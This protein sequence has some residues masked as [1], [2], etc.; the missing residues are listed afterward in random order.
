[1]TA[2]RRAVLAFLL[3][4]LGVLLTNLRAFPVLRVGAAPRPGVSLLVP[5]R[6]EVGR[7]A[8]T[9]GT[10]AAQ[11]V[12]ELVVLDD[13]ST[14]ATAA[15]ARTL[16]ADVPHARVVSGAPPPPG[17]VGKTWA[18][19]QLAQHAGGQVL[20]F[21]DCD[22][23]V[24]PGGLAAALAEM[25]R[26]GA[27]VFS[28]FPRQVTETWGERLTTPVVDDVLLG[29]LPFAL[30]G[31]D[32]PAAAT[33][34]GS[35]LAVTRTAH[36]ELGGFAAVRGEVVEDVALARLTR[37]RG[38]R[39]GLALGGDVVATRMYPGYA[40]A[41][42]GLGRGLLPVTGGSRL[43]LA[44]ATAWLLTVHTGPLLLAARDRRWLAP[45]LLTVGQ[46]FLVERKTRH[47]SGAQALLAPFWPVAALP[48]LATALRREQTWR[49]RSTASAARSGVGVP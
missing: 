10:L 19:H 46:R 2:L 11:P 43:R 30:L 45:L 28:V 48:V 41:V 38:L 21:A 13:C 1:M 22:V 12:D 29:F 32:V 37:R 36:D 17:W 4:K 23:A 20:V 3:L 35:L 6:D 24:A 40:A 5:V 16:L 9:L 7:L 49:G 44:A 26:Q 25:D 33:A 15:L 39:L 42:A 27:P 8:D 47:G 14:D 18:C 31:A 34:N